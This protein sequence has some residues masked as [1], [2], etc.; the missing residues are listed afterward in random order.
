MM[1]MLR[2]WLHIP[3]EKYFTLI[4]VDSRAEQTQKTSPGMSKEFLLEPYKD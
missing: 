2:Q 1:N 3:V 4:P